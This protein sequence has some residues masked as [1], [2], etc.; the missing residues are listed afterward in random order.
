MQTTDAL[1]QESR[2]ENDC[3]VLRD[4]LAEQ[5][6]LA[7]L[8][9]E[10]QGKVDQDL[11]SM[12]RDVEVL[13]DRL[14]ERREALEEARETHPLQDKLESLREAA[15]NAAK[16]VKGHKEYLASSWPSDAAKTVPVGDAFKVQLRVRKGLCVT[17]AEALSAALHDR[18]LWGPAVKDEKKFQAA[19]DVQFLRPL[20]DVEAGARLPGLKAGDTASIAVLG[21][22]PGAE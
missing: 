14:A 4:I 15:A 11:H 12:I 17:N 1:R 13:E 5:E 18:Q 16:S 9:E 10:V 20:C 22:G 8:V 3:A 21:G 7:G 19:L 6:R 2:L